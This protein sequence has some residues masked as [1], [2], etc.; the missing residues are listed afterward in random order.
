MDQPATRSR[1]LGAVLDRLTVTADVRD[2]ALVTPRLR[3]IQLAGPALHDLRWTPGQ[4]VRVVVRDV[5]RLRDLGRDLLRTYTVWA[6]DPA[7]TLDLGVLD[8]PGAGPGALWAR[9][10]APGAPVAFR[11]PEGRFVPR[12]DAAH[13]VLVG[14]ETAAVA[15]AAMLAALPPDAPVHGVVQVRDAADRFTFPRSDELTWVERGA[16]GPDADGLVAAVRALPLPAGPGA[17]YVA[18]EARS[19]QAVVRHLVQERGLPR[20]SV[21]VKPFWAPGRRGLD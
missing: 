4:H 11:R 19:C 5:E 18:G 13:H 1:A 21:V 3:R 9:G 16:A 20:R 14:D 15:F 8:H 2:V 10:I 6:F 7:G 17:A 12:P